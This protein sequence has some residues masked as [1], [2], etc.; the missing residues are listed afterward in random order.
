[1]FVKM[2]PVVI[3]LLGGALGELLQKPLASPCFTILCYISAVTGRG[4]S[5]S[6]GVQIYFFCIPQ[7]MVIR[8]Q[9]TSLNFTSIYNFK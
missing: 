4:V 2:T 7:D 5:V 3:I 6:Q 1:L 8:Q 9:N